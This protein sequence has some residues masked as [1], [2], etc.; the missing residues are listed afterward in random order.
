MNAEFR[1]F[2][3]TSAKKFGYTPQEAAALIA[4]QIPLSQNPRVNKMTLYRWQNENKLRMTIN[5][6]KV[7]VDKLNYEFDEI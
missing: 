3:Q 5:E 2:G 4:S 7:T 1:R 6:I